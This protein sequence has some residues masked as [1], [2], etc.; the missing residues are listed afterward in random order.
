MNARLITAYLCRC[1]P[2]EQAI[3]SVADVAHRVASTVIRT[4]AAAVTLLPFLFGSV[5]LAAENIRFNQRSVEDGLSQVAVQGIVQDQQGFI[6]MGTQQGLNRFDGYDFVNFY[7]DSADPTS[8]SDDFIWA[9][10]ADAAGSIWVG[11]N[12]GGLNRLDPQTGKFQHYRHDPQDPDSIGGISVRT[13]VSDAQGRI[14][15]GTDGGGVSRLD[16]ERG[17]F[18][19]FTHNADD[20][21]S[22]SS[23]R[24]KALHVDGSGFIWVGTDGGGLN[25]IDPVRE[26]VTQIPLGGITTERVRAIVS[27]PRGMLWVG[28]N[29]HGLF[30]VDP[31]KG[32]TR[33]YQYD[34]E[35]PGSLSS[36]SIR[37][38]FIDENQ[39]VWI[40][41]DGGGVSLLDPVTETFTRIQHES[42]NPRSLSDNHVASIYQDRGGVIWIGTY[43]GVN[44]WNPLM[45]AFQTFARREGL[46]GELSG[47]LVSSFAEIDDNTVLVGTVGTGIDAV[48]LETGYA[49]RVDLV[50]GDT[51]LSDARVMALAVGDAG[52]I[53]AGTRAGGLNRLDTETGDWRVYRADPDDP[54]GLAADGVTSL[55]FADD[56][57]LWVG[58][59]GGGLNL[60]DISSGQFTQFRHDPADSTS[61]CSDRVI[62]ML[63]DRAGQLWVNTDDGGFCR[64]EAETGRFTRYRH[65]PEDETSLS[66]DAVWALA[67]D[68]QGNLWIGTAD[69]GL[70]LWRANDRRSN[71]VR[72]TRIDESDGLLSTR[73]YGILSDAKGR[74]WVSNSR[75]LSRID[76][77]SLAMR[78]YSQADGLQDNDF[79]FA[80]AFR[81]SNG[82]LFF[83]GNAG[84][85]AFFP[86]R[87]GRN[88]HPPQV[89]LTRLLKN[90]EAQPISA[91]QDAQG[92][93]VL[94]HTDQHLTIEYS[95]LDFT[96]PQSNRYQHRLDGFDTDWIDDDG[97]H[98]VTYTNLQSGE[99]LLRVRAAN[100][101]GVWSVQEL[102]VPI[103][104]QPAPWATWWAQ[105]SYVLALALV[106]VIGFRIQ[107]QRL[108]RSA[109]LNRVQASLISEI[110]ERQVREAELANVRR[111]A[112]RYLDVVEVIILALDSRGHV[113][114][115]NQKGI[116]VLGYPEEE[117]LGR[118]FYDWFVPEEQRD[119][120]RERFQNIDQY[121]Y[122]ESLIRPKEGSDR[123]IAWHTIAAPQMDDEADAAETGGL[124]I[125]GTDVTQMRALEGQLRDAQ[126]MEALGTLARGVAHDFNNILSSILG[127]AQLSRAAVA[128]S[129]EAEDYF[130]K[131]ESSV[132]RARDLVARI[133]TFGRGGGQPPQP[134]RV[135]ASVREA[136]ELLRPVLP[137]NIVLETSLPERSGAVLADPTQLVQ[138][139]LNLCT[140]A[141]QAM[142]NDGGVLNIV[143]CDYTVGIEE[144]RSLS[145]LTPGA[146]VRISVSDTGPGMDDFTL[147]RIFDPF[148]TTRI[149]DEGTG[150][151][152]A[153]VH[154]IVSQLRGTVQ[155]FSEPGKGARFDIYLPCCSEQPLESPAEESEPASVHGNETVLFVDDEAPVRAIAEEALTNLGYRVLLAEDGRAGL[156]LFLQHQDE[157]DVVITDQTMPNML[158]H[159][160][161]EQIKNRRDSVPVILMSGAG[162]NKQEHVD[163]FVEKPFTLTGLGQA[164]REVLAERSV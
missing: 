84:F 55:R 103:L 119:Q 39:Q 61:I 108:A 70:N 21:N 88:E 99:Y 30:R 26:L 67:E 98:R 87:I 2:A 27:G 105:A 97:R 135:E 127:Y 86:D 16:I 101:D 83:G 3:N 114:L 94:K 116:R 49:Q 50:D 146:H 96:N 106:V 136:V 102:Q 15:A 43:R 128:D 155:V 115:V 85:N 91:L 32:V 148:F 7:H 93:L 45:G 51:G 52:D 123:M 13:I 54:S 75:G 151:G 89:A 44:T 66:S 10:H 14:W 47:N 139:V 72:F 11:T 152:L 76:G 29:E 31:Q 157:I 161:A 19:R 80:A 56:Q 129:G 162:P 37:Q 134:V 81:A 28:T 79:S 120:V 63:K 95:A 150:L 53:W 57:H 143:V 17:T 59:F 130:D 46:P 113:T 9:L 132:D 133:L 40:G 118:N 153:Q 78:H 68:P 24:V 140:N 92:R 124:L 112:Q 8:L 60:L 164:V 71:V 73:A 125:S 144:A 100:N 90:Y 131:L 141:A 104:K 77:D 156:A 34:S 35:D 145:A 147:S 122:S 126:K 36:N 64:L 41:T 138:V 25:R 5:V 159:K 117:I 33:H 62:G 137:A 82:R 1:P 6:W 109:E 110:T 111:R 38:L 160:L 58:T 20:D 4:V 23:N 107:H 12:R 121:A 74:I 154:G 158:G 142:S 48:N 69:K 18:T 22:L 149:R 163:K 42:A 65:D